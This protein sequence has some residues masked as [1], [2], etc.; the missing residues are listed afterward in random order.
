M[1]KI[2]KYLVISI[3]AITY[4]LLISPTELRA[5][6]D[7][8]GC[9]TYDSTSAEVGKNTPV[10]LNNGNILN[11]TNTLPSSILQKF[12][13]I[14]NSNNTSLCA[15]TDI[16][17]STD[18]SEPYIYS[19]FIG[20]SGNSINFPY[21]SSFTEP[22]SGGTTIN[23]V[24]GEWRTVTVPQ[25]YGNYGHAEFG[26]LTL[27]L[28]NLLYDGSINLAPPTSSASDYIN[29]YTNEDTLL[30]DISITKSIKLHSESSGQST[31]FNV[32]A[33]ATNCASLGG[34]G[35]IK[36]VFM[37][38]LSS[39]TTINDYL[40]E[41]DGTLSKLKEI[42][43]F[44]TYWNKFSF[45]VDLKKVTD[46]ST[47]Y[48]T[49]GG[50]S[51][52]T[53]FVTSGG[54]YNVDTKTNVFSSS[55]KN[56]NSEINVVFFKDASFFPAWTSQYGKTIFINNIEGKASSGEVALILA[57]QL[58]KAIGG[59]NSTNITSS[60][61]ELTNPVNCSTHPATDYRGTDGYM[62]G[63]TKS[64]GCYYNKTGIMPWSNKY[65]RPSTQSIMSQTI[66]SMPKLPNSTDASRFDIISCGYIVA[67]LMGE[68][69]TKSNAS[70]YW[71]ICLNNLDSAGKKEI[72]TRTS[73]PVIN[74]ITNSGSNNTFT[75]SGSG[76]TSS[77]NIKLT[78]VTTASIK[79]INQTANS[80]SSINYIKTLFKKIFYSEEVKGATTNP[81]Y[82]IVNIT[83]S[84]E[85]SLT[86]TIPSYIP[87][88]KYKVSISGE[89]SNW[90]DTGLTVDVTGNNDTSDSGLIDENNSNTTIPTILQSNNIYT[91]ATGY[92]L[93][94]NNTCY[95]NPSIA[96]QSYVCNNGDIF[97]YDINTKAPMC[98]NASGFGSYS[99][100]QE[101]SCPS[102]SVLSGTQ[103]IYNTINPILSCVT[104][105]KLNSTKNDCLPI[106]E[107]SSL[108]AIAG[109]ST[110]ADAIILNWKNIYPSTPKTIS[111][112]RSES[113]TG[114]Y[115]RIASLS[116]STNTYIDKGITELT[117]KYYKVIPEF[118]NNDG[119][120]SVNNNA[121]IVSA[122]TIL[123]YPSPIGLKIPTKLI[124][125]NY[126]PDISL[127]S[128]PLSWTNPSFA[129]IPYISI[130]RSEKPDSEFKII[131]KSSVYSSFADT[132]PISSKT[133]YYRARYI[134][135]DGSYSKYSNTTSVL[136][137]T[138]SSPVLKVTANGTIGASLSWQDTDIGIKSFNIISSTTNQT[139]AT[140]NPTTFAYAISGLTPG[141]KYC[142]SVQTVF[143]DTTKKNSP[144]VC[145]IIPSPKI[146][147]QTPTDAMNVSNY[148][149][150]PIGYNLNIVTNLKSKTITSAKCSKTK[151][152]SS[153]VVI[154]NPPLKTIPFTLSS[155]MTNRNTT[156]K[157]CIYPYKLNKDETVCVNFIEFDSISSASVVPKALKMPIDSSLN[158]NN[159][160]S[161]STS[162]NNVQTN[163]IN[164]N[165]NTANTLSSQ[166]PAITGYTC[167]GNGVLEGNTCVIKNIIGDGKSVNKDTICLSGYS[168]INSTTCK[169]K[170]TQAT[171]TTTIV[172]KCGDKRILNKIDNKCYLTETSIVP[173]TATYSCPQ[174]YLL[175]LNNRLCSIKTNINSNNS[176]STAS[177]WSIVKKLIVNIFD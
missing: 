66:D 56:S 121:P 172:Y 91:C 80:K 9:Y 129:T 148:G 86:L 54:Q 131:G 68:T 104:G 65:Y 125:N 135:P 167:G 122:T 70:K 11:I 140:V 5:Y 22:L 64:E 90:N 99:A 106:T 93:Q 96:N 78:P 34:T 132:N 95:K 117:T 32:T 14:N 175:D 81:Y 41:I 38:V 17:Y 39:K 2:K 37:R 94:S 31:G 77:N 118:V 123:L 48:Y 87:N 110:N 165:I 130:E 162:T 120:I 85:S 161:N 23:G 75:L 176:T 13:F 35:P 144:F 12:N 163:Q 103:C 115:Y 24:Y 76:I 100:T 169:N 159:S 147:P 26:D 141:N 25:P 164:T 72:A 21:S 152:N 20:N 114:I 154:F 168:K 108:T 173:A 6:V 58:G 156:T 145:I 88:G 124:K 109:T 43:P 49:G 151:D 174:G 4:S 45:Y 126:V 119:T 63:S 107:V 150:C 166:I 139:I 69:P 61:G 74:S 8:T 84:N 149:A 15:L 29:Y 16:D 42:D 60:T 171:T 79:S 3:F 146:N 143:S 153:G 137:P 82:E 28:K 52:I 57:R 127:S 160:N 112:E 116:N 128:I 83:S 111:V 133:L 73:P 98:L 47:I 51:G 142:Y 44:K 27:F 50:S 170:T 59:L 157:T 30:S 62:Y 89:N 71:S 40:E 102:G 18:S 19:N 46:P 92:T 158:T 1:S 113:K 136:T 55:C 138:P 7:K 134:F 67:G 155:S 101:Y 53:D 10:T 33:P 36:I 97:G 105:Y 177:V